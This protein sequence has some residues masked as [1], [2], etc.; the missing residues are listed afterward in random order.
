MT[1]PAGTYTIGVNS[2][3]GFQLTIPGVTFSNRINENYTGLSSATN[4]LTYGATRGA[5]DT[6]GTFTLASPLKTSITVDMFEQTGGDSLE[7]MIASGTICRKKAVAVATRSI[8]VV[9]AWAKSACRQREKKSQLAF[10]T[11]W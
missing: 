3:E 1:I 11:D 6:L 4:Q 5:A 7:V 10:A 9:S 2:D 8:S